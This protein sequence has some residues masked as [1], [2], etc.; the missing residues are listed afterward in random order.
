VL[1]DGRRPLLGVNGTP[2]VEGHISLGPGWSV[3]LYTDGLVERRHRSLDEG[4]A[5][6]S[7]VL[8]KE[9]GV[10]EDPARLAELM[11]S[12]DHRDDTCI[13]VATIAGLPKR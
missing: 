9:P 6:L 11:N 8:R 3:V 13:L 4:I 1:R 2:A 12:D 5:E 10:A 7:A